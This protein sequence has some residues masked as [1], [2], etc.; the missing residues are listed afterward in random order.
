MVFTNLHNEQST[1]SILKSK[2]YK[3]LFVILWSPNTNWGV[4]P[5]CNAQTTIT[6]I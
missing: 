5:F 2:E 6:K 4:K 3:H 1:N